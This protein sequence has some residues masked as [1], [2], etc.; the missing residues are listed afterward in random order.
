VR[1]PQLAAVV[2]RFIDEW[3]VERPRPTNPAERGHA[4]HR[5]SGFT[6]LV[7]C[8]SWT[9]DTLIKL[10]N[11]RTKLVP[12]W[13]A[14]EVLVAMNATHVLYDGTVPVVPHRRARMA[15]RRSCCRSNGFIDG[16]HGREFSPPDDGPLGEEYL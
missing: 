4:A 7:A 1:G 10:L 13:S 8:T 9:P 16:A 15:A 12:L 5:L 11:G 6:W 3:E 2:Q 14:D